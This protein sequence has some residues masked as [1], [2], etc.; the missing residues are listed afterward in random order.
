[1]ENFTSTEILLIILLFL[2]MIVG[3]MVDTYASDKFFPPKVKPPKWFSNYF[4]FWWL[5][6][7]VGL[8]PFSAIFVTSGFSLKILKIY[9]VFGLWGSV[10]WD[11]IFS[12]MWS[13]KWISD[14][15]LTW[16]WLGK[17]NIGFDKKTIGYFHIFR[18][19]LAAA[20]FYLL[21]VWIK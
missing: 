15:C 17:V 12:K 7:F 21:F 5:V 16:F 8:I 6:I 1:M 4:L 11:L 20:L 13:G 2:Y 10:I 18:I 19:I 3:G 9:A 14:S